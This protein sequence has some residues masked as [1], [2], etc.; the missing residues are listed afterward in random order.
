MPKHQPKI[1]YYDNNEALAFSDVYLLPAYSDIRSR[2][3]SQINTTTQIARGAPPLNIPFVSSGMDTVT[4]SEMATI[5]AL[6]GGIGE[7]HRNNLPQQQ[8]EFVRIVKEMMRVLEKDPPTVPESATINE[9]LLLLDRRKRGYVIVHKGRKFTREFSGIATTRDFLAGSGTTPI[10]KVMTPRE[11]LITGKE[12][13]S[14]AQAVKL[15]K[16]NKIEKLPIIDKQGKLIGVYTL[17]DYY[18]IEA[19]PNAATDSNGR[20]LVGAAIGVHSIDIER[21]HKLVNAGVDVLFLDIAHG[22]SI[23]SLEMIKTLKVQ[24]KIKT[25]IIVGN[26]ATKQAVLFAYDI[27]ADGIKIGIGPGFVCKTRNVAGTGVPQVTAI[28][29]AR[30]ALANKRN[31]P[32]IMADG[33]I[34]EPGDPPKAIVCGADSV[35]IGSVLAGTDKSPGDTVR[36]NGV[37]QKR[38]RGMASRGVFEDRRKMGDTTSNPTLYTP[39]GRETFTPFSGATE[40]LLYEYI[41]GLR[42]AMSYTGTHSIQ[43]MQNARLIRVSSHGGGEQNRSLN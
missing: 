22:H 27:G 41:G 28:L 30:E 42:S 29:E 31:A 2:H 11:K 25:P 3:G 13:T 19:Y 9:V 1:A 38:I 8:A 5:M 33:G 10:A 35:M 14:L 40:Q 16:E 43:E 37:L 15:M 7:I 32:P 20:L 6:H 23:Y 34:R 21:A 4:E 36:I 26:V 24:E 12:S 18:Q 17:K 39:E